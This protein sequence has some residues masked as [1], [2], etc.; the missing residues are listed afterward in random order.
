M[1]PSKEGGGG[2]FLLPNQ[3]Q[4]RRKTPEKVASKGE[5]AKTNRLGILGD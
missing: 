1:N 2:T 4:G 3:T 5:K